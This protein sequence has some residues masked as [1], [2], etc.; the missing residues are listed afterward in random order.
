M[1][2]LIQVLRMIVPDLLGVYV[3]GVSGGLLF[4]IAIDYL[5]D[6][7]DQRYTTTP[8][9]YRAASV[10]QRQ[11]QLANFHQK[12]VMRMGRALIALEATGIGCAIIGLTFTGTWSVDH[13][14][15]ALVIS[16]LGP[17][18][19]LGPAVFVLYLYFRWKLHRTG[20]S[21]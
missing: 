7:V 15:A 5:T 14:I 1:T 9:P 21:I 3:M 10:E 6:K 13:A 2:S 18:V 11:E 20:R 12:F 19:L 17:V 16:V 4:G 8:Q